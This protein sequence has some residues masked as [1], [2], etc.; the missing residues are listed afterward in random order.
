MRHVLPGQVLVVADTLGVAELGSADAAGGTDAVDDDEGE[1]AG[2]LVEGDGVGLD[3]LGDGVGLAEVRVGVGALVLTGALVGLALAVL[4]GLVTGLLD[5]AAA[6]ATELGPAATGPLLVAA[7][8]VPVALLVGVAL[9]WADGVGDPDPLVLGA[10]PL[11]AVPPPLPWCE[12]RSEST[13]VPSAVAAPPTTSTASAAAPSRTL[14]DGCRSSALGPDRRSPAAP[15]AARVPRS[16]TGEPVSVA[17]PARSSIAFCLAE[18]G[19]W[20][21][22]RRCSATPH[23]LLRSQVL[24][25]PILGAEPPWKRRCPAS[26][27]QPQ[28]A[29]VMSP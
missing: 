27:R 20:R 9:L 2:L 8:L 11:A 6:A 4:L 5:W 3:V 12:V 26:T 25:V 7:L 21:R 17:R 28:S 13:G 29:Y 16:R 24:P 18:F 22:K 14:R 15:T 1:G 10:P 23:E 19:A